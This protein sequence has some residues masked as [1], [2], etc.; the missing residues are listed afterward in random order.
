[1]N[2]NMKKYD[3]LFDFFLFNVIERA[4]RFY[5]IVHDTK[6]ENMDYYSDI[7]NDVYECL[8]VILASTMSL[9]KEYAHISNEEDLK[10]IITSISSCYD[11]LRSLHSEIG[12]LPIVDKQVELLR[13]K[14]LFSNG[15]KDHLKFDFSIGFRERVNQEVHLA[16]PL[17]QFKDELY[18]HSHIERIKDENP[19]SHIILPYIELKNPLAWPTIAH[20]ISH[21]LID[22]CFPNS[23][24]Y[25]DFKDFLKNEKIE[26]HSSFDDSM[27]KVRILEYWCD[28]LGLLIMGKAFW[29]AQYDAMFFAN[30]RPG[31]TA[32]SHPPSFLRLWLMRQLLNNRLGSK[33]NASFDNILSGVYRNISMYVHFEDKKID[34]EEKRLAM[35]FFYYLSKKYVFREIQHGVK[36]AGILEELLAG[37]RKDTDEDNILRINGL[38][39]SLEKDYPIPSCRISKNTLREKS[40]SIQ[41]VFLA[42]VLYR[43]L[44]LKNKIILEFKKIAN[45]DSNEDG[46]IEAFYSK[47]SSILG[48]FDTN[49]LRSIQLSEYFDLLKK[50][51]DTLVKA[52]KNSR[53]YFDNGKILNDKEIKNKLLDSSLKIIP[54][55]SED[56]IGSTSIDIRLGTSFQI[57]QPNHS[58]I[59]DL[60]FSKT[61]K[62]AEN[63]SSMIDLE[64]LEGIV[65]S[66]GQFVLGHT[67]EYLVLPNNLAAEIEGRSSYARLGLEIHMT[68]GFIDPGFNGV[69][70]L[71][72]FN[73]GPNPIKMYPGLRIGQLRFIACNEPAKPYSRNVYAKYRGLLA[74][75]GSLLIKDYEI[76]CYNKALPKDEDKKEDI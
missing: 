74:H 6:Y 11:Q 69:L 60:I 26:Y 64:Y 55:I 57:Y 38:I 53:K 73:A 16:T 10:K 24:Y 33:T 32:D 42:G 58:G 61:L 71:E 21:R 56:Q 35:Q 5:R 8:Q 75:T 1:M 51:S 12:C 13:F 59:I 48:G 17:S 67:M 19:Q 4:S 22:F 40:T 66:P 34:I 18:T 76:D 52:K 65:L 14:R 7:I 46:K 28:F 49:L 68:A 15:L 54:L 23:D 43:E 9:V 47:I 25:R 2:S 20:E 62:E 63:N 72:I 45:N 44:K 41:E 3:P 50:D 30:I 31:S 29:F 37:F 27:I 39:D 36:L 70:T